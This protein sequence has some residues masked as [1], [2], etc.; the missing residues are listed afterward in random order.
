MVDVL[1]APQHV[2][3]D[4]SLRTLAGISVAHWVSHFHIFVLPM[5]FPYLK[6]QLG[7]GYIELGFA[8]TVFGLVSGLTQAPIGYLADHI[9]ARKVLLIG[10][11]VGGLALIMLG[12]H[13]SYT[14]LIV[15]AALL[16]LANSV[17]HPCDYAILSAH[18]DVR[19]MGRAF[20][21]HTFAGFLGGAVAPAIMAA[22][23][24]WLGGLGAL[25]VA[26][27]VGPVVALL[28]IVV[29]IPDASSAD[30]KVDGATPHR[31][32]VITPAIIML[33]F[34]FMLLGLSNAGIS[35]FGVV[36]LMSG[37]GVTFSAANI[38][39]TAFLGASAAGVLAGG[40]LADRTTRHGQVAAGCFGINALIMLV[41]AT[42]TLPSVV[43][44]AAMGIAG[45][46]GGVIAPSRDMLVRNAAPPGAAGR[47]FGIVSTGFNFSG[48]L[49][50]LLFGWIMDQH[51]PHWVF[52]ASV[53]FM[54]LTVLLALI[55]D[56]KPKTR[57][58]GPVTSVM[59]S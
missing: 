24:A 39:L 20:S 5:L 9:G 29:G 55:T 37:Y 25:I 18:M 33:T 59:H 54:V 36:A 3:A 11:C 28:L 16:G 8:L 2:K 27:A 21:I 52:G 42:T 50:P 4:S 12:M 41:I 47:A 32:S 13:L 56:R 23:V 48:I 14:S 58:E 46:L 15:C 19:R 49:S 44:T 6:A 43:L 38:A 17:Y 53:A 35:N 7:V 26:G 34:F 40:Y 51:L 57:S 31:Q 22:L 10:L 1:T 45:F 30:R